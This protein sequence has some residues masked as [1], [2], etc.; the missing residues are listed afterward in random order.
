MLCK[1]K[2]KP[3]NC[4]NILISIYNTDLNWGYLFCKKFDNFLSFLKSYSKYPKH[5]LITVAWDSPNTRHLFIFCPRGITSSWLSKGL[6]P[7]AEKLSPISILWGTHRGYKSKEYLMLCKKKLKPINCTNI[8]ISI[9]N[10][11]LNW[12]Y[13]FCL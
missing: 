7:T 6:H 4:T 9:Y 5:P 13:L 12:G 10:T 11:D 2:L 1:K 8:L 3:I